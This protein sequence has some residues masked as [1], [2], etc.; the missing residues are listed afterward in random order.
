MFYSDILFINLKRKLF[1]LADCYGSFHI[2]IFS[3]FFC[4]SWFNIKQEKYWT[5]NSVR[6]DFCLW[7]QKSIGELQTTT[8]K[9]S[10]IKDDE[11]VF[12]V[13][14]CFS[15]TKRPSEGK[16]HFLSKLIEWAS[17]RVIY[18]LFDQFLSF[19]IFQRGFFLIF[20]LFLLC[21]KTQEIE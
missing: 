14:F 1:T 18:S 16:W 3:F 20:V 6:K 13:F 8:R 12:S 19:F 10:K 9:I 11:G 17:H 4:V 15:K 5:K 7:G 2:V 21:Q